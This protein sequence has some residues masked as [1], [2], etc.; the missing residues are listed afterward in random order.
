MIVK[1]FI[2]KQRNLATI[3]LDTG[4]IL[5][6]VPVYF[7]ARVKWREDWFMGIQEAFIALAKDEEIRGRTRSV[8]DYM[9]GKLGFENYIV[10]QQR[11]ICEELKLDKSNVSKA[12]SILLKK[13]II[14]Q[15]PK[16][17]RTKSYRLNSNFGWK[18]K[19]KNLAEERQSRQ[20]K[21][22]QK[23]KPYEHRP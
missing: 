9:F 23:E 19:V 12:I 22:V 16:L 1:N 11:E 6:G 14:L 10:I 4:E 15:G 7:N 17:G 3:D 21:L 2:P 8:L 20:L 5:D 13:R 18:G